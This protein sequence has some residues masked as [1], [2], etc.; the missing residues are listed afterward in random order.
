M[1][2][3]KKKMALTLSSLL[4]VAAVA[5]LL[6]LLNLLF[7]PVNAR[8]DCTEAKV[9]TLSAGTRQIL[10]K[11]DRSVSIRF[12]YSKDVANMPVFLKT[13]ASRVEDL[14]GEYKRYGGRYLDIKKLNPKPDSDEEDSANLDGING[15]PLDALGNDLVY[16]GIAVSSAGK[17]TI[18]PF[19]SPEKEAMLEYELTRAISEVQSVKKPKVAVLSP[20]RVMG[21]IDDPQAMMRGQGGMKPAWTVIKELRRAYQVEELAAGAS[22]V[23]ADIDLLV[24]LHPKELSPE[25]LYAI[26]QFVL[27]GGRLLAF[28]DPVCMVDL[29]NAQQQQHMAPVP[30]D[31][32]V[33]L[34]A[35]GVSFS[36]GKVVVD[37]KLATRLRTGNGP[38]LMPTVLSVTRA[39]I[40]SEDPA[41][42]ALSN[43]VLF[44]A[45]AFS[46]KG[47]EGLAKTV[48]LRSSD[49]VQ[50]MESF[51]IQRSPADIM[52]DFSSDDTPKELAVKLTGT[53]RTAFPDGRPGAAA[54]GSEAADS[55]PAE[56]LRESARPGAVVLV[57]DADM[58]YDPFCVRASNFLGQEIVQPLNDNIN[59]ALNMIDNL[60]GD[61]AL[62]SI[63][64]RQTAAR[65]FV[66]VR[67]MEADAEKRFQDKIAKLEN[68]L[69]K[70]QMEIQGMQR[71]R[72]QGERELL[73][74]E[75]RE[76]LKQYRRKE[77]EAK[78]EL[79]AVRKQLRRDIDSLQNRLM[80]A[81]TALMPLLVIA[82]GLILAFVK[83]RRNKRQ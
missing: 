30:S 33:L 66:R 3:A 67:E 15:Q 21:G 10:G 54:A 72:E 27:R 45:G 53:F 29:Q 16:L 13:Y 73:S 55:A 69:R 5:V 8:W 51:A 59:L 56:G 81:N 38:E 22:A 76:L 20:L 9:Y 62:F 71:N 46:G 28:L 23:G 6:I 49:D 37:R 41:A 57:G 79:K 24:L 78:Q 39:E 40:A 14:L 43:L 75:Q 2:M 64:S 65:P 47:A 74:A 31:L 80:L 18:L 70:V 50:L 32:G 77:S 63:R 36:G 12:Y 60:L 35:W 48:L 61:S 4:G 17:T 34:E 7:K 42:A 44:T 19:L 52:K 58:L 68:D 11:L 82:G 25:T 26:D 83:S 1:S